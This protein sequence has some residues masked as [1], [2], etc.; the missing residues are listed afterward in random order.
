[1]STTRHI[2]SLADL[3]ALASEVSTTLL[4]NPEGA[5]VLALSGD[6]GAGKTTFVQ[7]LAKQLG[8]IEVVTSPTYLIM[9]QYET[10]SSA[11]P[12]LVHMDAY[13]I[14]DLSELGPLRFSEILATPGLLLCIEWAE[15]IAAALPK[16]HQKLTFSV[17]K[18]DTRTITYSQ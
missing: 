8:V 12:G 13:R 9:R 18:E 17:G 6:L 4:P 11:F 15:K 2:G 1:M 7:L 10:K 16:A 5:T 14:D 3:E